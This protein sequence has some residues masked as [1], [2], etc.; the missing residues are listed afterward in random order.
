M[1]NLFIVLI[2]LSLKNY[3]AIAQSVNPEVFY[4]KGSTV[5]IEQLV[6]DYDRHFHKPT[7]NQTN[8]KYNLWGTDLGVPF[9]HNGKTYV[10]FGDIP[11]SD[12]DPIAFTNDS[13][14]EDGIDLQ[15]ITKA[16]GDYKPIKIPGISQGAF[17]VPVEGIS[18][19]DIMYIYHTT[20]NMKRLA[21]AKSLDNGQTFE[22]IEDT[23]SINHFI[24][25]SIIKT[26]NS[27]WKPSVNYTHLLIF[28]SGKYRNSNVYL[29]IQPKNSIE[30]KNSIQY[31]KGIDS[32][33]NPIWT[34]K[35]SEA[36]S[37]FNQSCVGEFSVTYNQFIKK[38]LMLYN[39]DNPRGINFRTADNPW[40][41]W[42]K[43]QILFDPWL[44]HGYC[45]FIHT[46]WNYSVCDSVHDN[47]RKYEWGGE[48]GP[49][50]FENF[51][52]GTDTSTTI[53]YTMS[54]WNPYTVV[55][56]KSTLI[57]PM[58]TE[59]SEIQYQNHFLHF[60][61]NPI[62][63]RLYIDSG[64]SIIYIY[65]NVGKLIEKTSLNSEKLNINTSEWQKGI[66]IIKSID[67]FNHTIIKKIIKL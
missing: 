14:P 27:D 55:L 21:L 19:N 31:F 18:I 64:N 4:L 40:G 6:G 13:F 56:M 26:D 9:N 47:G 61:P 2:I 12:E 65:N 29:A 53:Y 58:I 49:Y 25:V 35:E 33:K 36:K 24:N 54:T 34:K 43:P 51:A 39:C 32:N 42:S 48:Y 28:G 23:I 16:N 3:L 10:L 52:I 50:Q 62:T 66:Y 41:S 37:L 38:W 57:K 22:L 8:K 67:S 15:F 1:K 45:N 60:N 44:D 20:D 17:E 63:D 5:K 11:L 30:D 59:V 7:H 46:D